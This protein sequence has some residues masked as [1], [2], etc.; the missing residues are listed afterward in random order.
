[1]ISRVI[2]NWIILRKAAS[3]KNVQRRL[4][5]GNRSSANV[6]NAGNCP[7]DDIN[8]KA[9]TLVRI[10]NGNLGMH[11]KKTCL[12]QKTGGWSP[13]RKWPENLVKCHMNVLLRE[14]QMKE[15]E[16]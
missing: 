8:V 15:R 16:D 9:K 4:M 2:H 13:R 5:L 3:N 12:R 10:K 14:R 1:M 11:W 6:I 7:N